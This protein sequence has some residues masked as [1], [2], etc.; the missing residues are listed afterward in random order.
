MRISHRD[1]Y[2][3]RV[4]WRALLSSSNVYEPMAETP[5]NPIMP[6]F[7]PNQ[8]EA[9]EFLWNLCFYAFLHYE[10]FLLW[11]RICR[12]CEGRDGLHNFVQTERGQRERVEKG[13]KAWRDQIEIVLS[14]LCGRYGWPVIT[15][16]R[17]RLNGRRLPTTRV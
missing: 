2:M 6:Y 12:S 3:A 9:Y 17:A 10:R 11:N 16:K 7:K 5:P 15:A 1:W 8:I 13:I 14:A 4:S